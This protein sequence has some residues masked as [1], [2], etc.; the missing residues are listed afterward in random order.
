VPNLAN[1]DLV[2]KTEQR[3]RIS[4]TA[5]ELFCQ[6]G[7][8]SVSMDD[9][10]QHLAISKKTIYKWF[11]NKNEVVIAA[12]SNYLDNM[13][14]IACSVCSANNAV[15]ELFSLMHLSRQIFSQLNQSIFYELQKYHPDAWQLWIEHKNVF[16][17]KKIKENLLRG[18][19]EGLFRNDLDVEVMARLRLAQ[20]EIPFNKDYFPPHQYELTHVQLVSLELYMLGIATLKGHKLINSLKHIIE[21]E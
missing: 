11:D 1:M 14:Q 4:G 21:E 10:A 9:I 13:E 17:L 12:V 18:I 19:A 3:N 20:I 5:F 2:E 6:R 8:K 15:E 16:T 7:I